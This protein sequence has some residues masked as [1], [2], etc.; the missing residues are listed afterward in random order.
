VQVSSSSE[1]APAGLNISFGTATERIKENETEALLRSN[2]DFI[3]QEIVKIR[4]ALEQIR[5]P[6][7]LGR[8]KVNF[9][10]AAS[11]SSG[12]DLGL[13]RGA[14]DDADKLL[15]SVAQFSSMSSGSITINGTDISID[16]SVD[17]LNDVISRINA[18]AAGVTSSL[19]NVDQRFMVESNTDN[20]SLVLNSGS[21]GFFAAVNMVDGT[22]ESSFG[23]R[24]SPDKNVMPGARA[25]KIAN[26]IEDFTKAFNAIF[27]DSKILAEEDSSLEEFLETLRSD[28][29][30]S[31]QEGFGSTMTEVDSGYGIAFD[32][33]TSANRI[34]DFTLLDKMDLVKKLTKEGSDVN[35]LFFGLNRKDDDGLI[36][37]ILN[38]LET[39]EKFLKDI[40]GTTGVF[41]DVSA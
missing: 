11:A 15:S 40:R 12:S 4:S 32:F 3:Y 8:T 19:F 23:S 21:T 38:S 33:T 10:K 5:N 24:E 39:H 9:V 31:V 35:E 36:E 22:S 2:L 18:S 14:I 28:L 41:V 26:A 1:S 30:S 34:F 20:Q 37:K 17:S 25:T 13:K 27:D 29:K 6:L 7:N 16:V